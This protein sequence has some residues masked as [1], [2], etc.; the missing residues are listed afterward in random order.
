M[1]INKLQNAIR[2]QKNPSMVAFS[3][4]KNQIPPAFLEKESD[5][6]K[7]YLAYA[8]ALLTALTGVVPGVRFRFGTFA[9]AGTQGLETLRELLS[10]A[11]EQKFYILL[12]VPEV[13]SGADAALIQ[14]TMAEN[15]QYD[16]L[17]LN[18]YIGSDGLIPFLNE[19]KQN[20]KDL[21]LAFRTGNKSASEM[22][23][24]LAG[25]RLLYTVMADMASRL[26]EEMLGRKE[27]TRLAGVG[28]ATSADS[29]RTLRCKYP[30]MFLLIDG[31]DYSGANA[32][33]CA[34]AFD[35]LGHGA[36]ACADNGI[37]AAWKEDRGDPIALA[38]EAAER[39]KK[40]LTRYITIL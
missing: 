21:F 34:P 14:E 25:S 12:D 17:L 7:A 28:P 13:Y 33:N 6:T 31:Y 2:K 35:N 3:L 24:Q 18:G 10:F 8:K 36:I 5:F 32:K 19:M 29:L 22:Q 16:G 1:S 26:A 37:V 15:W 4:D 39:M 23:D 20:E 40:N 27:Y 30:A 11:W 9:V 38:V